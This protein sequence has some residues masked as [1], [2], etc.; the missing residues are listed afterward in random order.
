M[1]EDSTVVLASSDI[2][3]RNYCTIVRKPEHQGTMEYSWP[4]ILLDVYG[5][6]VYV[7]TNSEP[8]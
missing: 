3:G 6:S 8:L 1:L 2:E 4:P 7:G 5:P